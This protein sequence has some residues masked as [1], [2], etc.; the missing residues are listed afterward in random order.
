M[1][2]IKI[3]AAMAGGYDA[4]TGEG[5]TPI[6]LTNAI[7]IADGNSYVQGNGYTPF[8]TTIAATAPFNS[9]GATVL[10]FGVG[11][12]TTPNM[13][14][15]QA[16]QI[17]SEYVPGVANILLVVEGGNDIYFNGSVANALANLETYCLA[18]RAAGFKVI[19]STTIPRD[20]STAFGDNSATY[21]AKLVALNNGLLAD[22]SWYD[23]IIRP[24]LEPIFADFSAGGYDADK[25]HP[26]TPGQ[27]RH[28]EL[29]IDAINSLSE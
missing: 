25:V 11:S 21:N 23:G 10:N 27:A 19:V 14:S 2:I 1:S 15:D 26:N 29:F 17:L 28:A 13:I 9:N 12:Q 8:T 4:S 22:N 16:A 24:D 20:Q 7:I 5:P 3:I 6:N 18:A